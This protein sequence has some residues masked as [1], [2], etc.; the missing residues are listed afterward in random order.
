[1]R[2][3]TPLGGTVLDVFLGSG[4]TACA[5]IKEGFRCVGIDQSEEYCQIAINRLRGLRKE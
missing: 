5:A 4:S 1:M 3:V 2:L